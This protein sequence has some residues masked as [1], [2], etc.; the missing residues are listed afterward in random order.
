MKRAGEAAYV[1]YTSGSTGNPKGVLVGHRNVVNFVYGIAEKIDFSRGKTILALTTISFDIFVLET[2]L[3]LLKGLRVV[4]AD[5]SQQ[6]SPDALEAVIVKNTVQM[7][8]FTP[9]R[10]KMFLSG[11]RDLSSLQRVSEL[12]LGGEALPG[13]LL[14]ALKEGFYGKIYNLYGPTE[15]TVWST[16]KDLSAQRNVDIGQPIANT[17]IYIVD[18]SN[19]LQPIGVAGELCIGGDGVAAGYLDNPELSGERFVPNPFEKGKPMYRT[20]DLAKWLPDGNIA[21]LGRSDYQVK[22]RGFRV[23][24]A[25]IELHLL[26]HGTVREALVIDREINGNTYLCAYL[27]G[28]GRETGNDCCDVIPLDFP[29][30]KEFLA[31]D[32]PAYMIPSHFVQLDKIPLTSNGKIDTKALPEPKTGTGI[33]YTAPRGPLETQMQRIWQKVL[34]VEGIGRDDNFFH[35]GGHSIKGIQLLNEIHKEFNVKIPL[36]EIFRSPTIKELTKFIGTATMEKFTFLQPGEKKEYYELSHAQKRMYILQQ[37]EQES[38]A[39]NLPQIIPFPVEPGVEPGDIPERL[40]KV[41][42]KLI[43]R[44]DSLRTSFHML[45]P[46]TPGR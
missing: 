45:N 33:E 39:Y 38:T 22:I 18:G 26:K 41:F 20:G 5:E 8:Q 24:L 35:T 16:L 2:F 6:V 10:L 32:L 19:A 28:E 17:R 40:E 23:E 44:H 37:M 11:R 42:K 15:T 21:F 43:Q 30:I 29:A 12:M 14:A 13:E 27:I 31:K 36:A 7:L 34:G 1:I 25:E 4:M 9:S 3:P 46:V